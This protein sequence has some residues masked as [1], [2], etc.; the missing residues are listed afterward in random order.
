MKVSKILFLLLIMVF[1]PLNAQETYFT[2]VCDRQ[3]KTLQVRVDGE[4]LSDPF[5][6]LGGEDH[7][8]IN[9]DV[10]NPGF[11]R[12][13][14]KLIHC[15]ADWT[16]SKLSPIEYMNGFQGSTI[17]DFANAMSTTVQ[18]TNYRLVFPNEDIQPKVSGNYA[19]QVY[20]E[21][22]PSH[23]V[24]TACFSIYEP[25]VSVAAT[26]SGNTDIDT[27]QSHQQVSFTINHKNFPITY[28]QTDLKIHVYQNN[29][30]DNAV[31]DLQ[32]MS[33]LENQISYT[34]NR[35][36]IFPRETNIAAWNS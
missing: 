17:D 7:I 11:G 1:A 10:L 18:Y 36:L 9:F 5:I 2:N 19:L 6:R 13:A 22:D 32:P 20:N 31:T 35:N 3:I 12:Y 33:I 26:V 28:P 23:I 15:D 29:R 30:R 34:N 27:N 16:R 25:M 21:E 14:Y 24:F 4:P 8:E